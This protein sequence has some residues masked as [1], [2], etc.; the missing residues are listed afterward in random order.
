MSR[1]P[2]KLTS[3]EALGSAQEE[4]S[5]DAFSRQIDDLAV[6]RTLEYGKAVK[7]PLANAVSLAVLVCAILVVRADSIEQS[8]GIVQ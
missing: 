1:T 6:S 5:R 3:Q 4:G 8:S 7:K 2:K